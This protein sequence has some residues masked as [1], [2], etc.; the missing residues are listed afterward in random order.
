MNS[1][2][3]RASK[4]APQ[5]LSDE[6]APLVNYFRSKRT[7]NASP[8]EHNGGPATSSSASGTSSQP[9]GALGEKVDT[10][11]QHPT[12][13]HVQ[14]KTLSK[15]EQDVQEPSSLDKEL[16]RDGRSPSAVENGIVRVDTNDSLATVRTI[17]RVPGNNNYYEKGGL[18][19]YGDG[20]DHVHEEPVGHFIVP[21]PSSG[22]QSD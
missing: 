6:W 20:Q 9:G 12:S 8:S 2:P 7:S 5:N 14:P 15:H 4:A 1:E 17:S 10:S 22:D 3:K 21:T 16:E 18:R 11:L 13:A 19:T